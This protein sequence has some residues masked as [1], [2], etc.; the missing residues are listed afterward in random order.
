[1]INEVFNL[2]DPNRNIIFNMTLEKATA[3]VAEGGP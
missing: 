3:I 1:M 2:T